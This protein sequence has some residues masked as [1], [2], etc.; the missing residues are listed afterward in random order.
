MPP[1]LLNLRLYP[2]FSNCLLELGPVVL[3]LTCGSCSLPLGDAE[4][5]SQMPR[6][7]KFNLML[8]RRGRFERALWNS[9]ARVGRNDAI[10]CVA[11]KGLRGGCLGE[12]VLRKAKWL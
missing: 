4:S 7:R 11:G 2:S 10:G 6:R 8:W 5:E 3:K 12:G 9:F 1:F